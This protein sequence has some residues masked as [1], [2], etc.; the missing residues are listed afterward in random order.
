MTPMELRSVQRLSLPIEDTILMPEVCLRHTSSCVLTRPFDKLSEK[1]R[2]TFLIDFLS[3]GVTGLLYT[4]IVGPLTR[5]WPGRL[6]TPCAPVV[7]DSLHVHECTPL[8]QQTRPFE[9]LLPAGANV[10]GSQWP[11]QRQ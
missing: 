10:V 1:F 3:S 2:S 6:H 5:A 11:S 7:P 8:Q 9:L 4:M